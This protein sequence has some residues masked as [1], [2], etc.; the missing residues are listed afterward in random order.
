MVS[1]MPYP[2]MPYSAIPYPMVTPAPLAY[3]QP[4][5]VLTQGPIWQMPPQAPGFTP[6]SPGFTPF[7]NWPQPTD[8]V[9]L[10]QPPLPSSPAVTVTD[11]VQAM[12]S[13]DGSPNAKAP[14]LIKGGQP[15]KAVGSKAADA[16]TKATS[17]PVPAPKSERLGNLIGRWAAHQFEQYPDIVN[18][19]PDEVFKIDPERLKPEDLQELGTSIGAEIFTKKLESGPAPMRWLARKVFFP[20][21]KKMLPGRNFS[22]L[23]NKGLSSG[24]AIASAGK[25]LDAV[26][27]GPDLGALMQQLSALG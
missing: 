17:A 8:T 21:V 5:P 6:V 18:Q 14:G 9:A 25:A 27:D 15:T 11:D 1:S 26:S 3:P 20:T 13:A 19:L 22:E 10:S 23:V 24:N 16:E 7:Q 4:V 12:P 2:P